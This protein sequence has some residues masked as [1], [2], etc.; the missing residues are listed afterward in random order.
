MDEMKGTNGKPREDDTPGVLEIL[1]LVF[2]KIDSVIQ[3]IT[4][5]TDRAAAAQKARAG[6]RHRM[7]WVAVAVVF[8]VI[9]VSGTL[10]GVNK[11]DGSTFTFLLGLVV[12]YVLT[13]VRESISGNPL[14]DN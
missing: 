8:F 10:T 6:F 14:K 9:A 4:A 2:N 7:A 5:W 1:E 13:F 11:I 3:L 12:G